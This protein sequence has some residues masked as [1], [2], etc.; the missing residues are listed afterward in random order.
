MF[1]HV[2]PFAGDPILALVEVFAADPRPHKVNLSIGIYF[3]EQGRI[4]VLRSV[5]LAEAR[6]VAL[7]GPKPYLP[8]EGAA[9][10]RQAVQQLLFGADHAVL[11]EQRVATIQSVGSSGG[12]KVG[13][14]FIKRWFP[15][16]EVWVSDPTWDNHRSMFEG[17]GIAVH[18][19]PYYDAAGGG[20]RFDAM[21][22]ALQ[23]VPAG[24]I[25]LLHACCHNPTGVDLSRAQWDTLIPLLKERGLIPYLDLAYQGFGDGI[26]ADAYAVRALAASGAS[27]F[28]ANSFSKSMSVYGE[29]CGALSVVC[30]DAKQAD[31]VLGQLKFTVRRNYSSP[32]IHGGQIVAHVLADAD[33][34]PMWE[35]E[36]AAMRQ[37]I[38]A[39]RRA[40]HRVISAK[41]PGRDFGYFLSQRGMFSYTG[42]SA[43]QVD[44]LR[45]QYA[46]YLVRSGR[47]CVAGLNDDN[48][49][50]TAQAMAEVM[51][52]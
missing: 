33:L 31:C 27:F 19:Y 26:D 12:L 45:E 36:L 38:G 15:H 18:G 13:A 29:R 50:R 30:P 41:V 7:G 48:V 16:S 2:E 37:R 6:V 17:A 49:E 35:S 44:R 40:L 32:P 46:V 25:V 11:R 34:R 10:F 28:V 1:A 3:D 52:A 8:I 42:L 20:V 39:M 14:D 47:I 24:S 22:D 21:L 9:N 4:P 23:R 43:A 51:Q 5:Q